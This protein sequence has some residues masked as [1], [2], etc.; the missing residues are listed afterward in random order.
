VADNLSY[1]LSNVQAL[2]I[3][4]AQKNRLSVSFRDCIPA[5]EPDADAGKV[6]T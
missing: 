3:I 5:M 6:F 1:I 2:K 4:S